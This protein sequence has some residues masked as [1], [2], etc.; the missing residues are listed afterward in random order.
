MKSTQDLSIW[1]NQL[2]YHLKLSLLEISIF[3][4]KSFRIVEHSPTNEEA[5]IVYDSDI[6]DEQLDIN[7]L[8]YIDPKEFAE[9]IIEL[10]TINAEEL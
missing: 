7:D 10:N 8:C 6:M 5:K 2:A 9:K 3:T 1:L 4:D